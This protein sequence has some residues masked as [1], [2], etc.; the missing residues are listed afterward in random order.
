MTEDSQIIADID[1][2]YS[3]HTGHMHSYSRGFMRHAKAW[4]THENA[5]KTHQH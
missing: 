3:N 1:R 2:G 4:K 5:H